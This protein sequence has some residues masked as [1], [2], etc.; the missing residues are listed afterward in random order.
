MVENYD[1]EY[2]YYEPTEATSVEFTGEDGSS[3]LCDVLFYFTMGEDEYIALRPQ[4]GEYEGEV[5]PYRYVVYEDGSYEIDDIID[6]EEY[7]LACDRVDE[8]LDDM[9]FDAMDGETEE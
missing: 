8:I 4:S 7:E 9:D 2:E 5:Y 1:E 3:F 6:D